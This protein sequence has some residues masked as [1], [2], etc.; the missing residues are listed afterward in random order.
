L[1]GKRVKVETP[2]HLSGQLEFDHYVFA[3]VTMSF[4]V[5]R[6]NLPIMEVYGT[7]GSLQC[8]DPNGFGGEVRLWTQ[9]TQ[10]WEKVPLTH[11]DKIGRGVGL[12][13]MARA[14]LNRRRA[15]ANG[16][17]G[18]HVVEVMEAF[19]VSAR[20]EKMI[21]MGSQCERPEPMPKDV[22]SVS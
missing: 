15:R 17:L 5:W 22:L 14:I 20:A 6:H 19:Y 18:L 10:E 7:E 16:E 13:D 12:A 4:D 21:R 1:H 8:P 3:T 2:T 11:A 9:K